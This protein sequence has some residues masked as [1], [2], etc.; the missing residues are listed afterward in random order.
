MAVSLDGVMVPMK[1]GGRAQKR[2]Q[3][4]AQDKHTFGPAGYQEVGCG[5]LSFYD[6]EGDRLST[7]HLGRMPEKHKATLKD[8]LSEELAAVLGPE[9]VNNFE[10]P[11][12]GGLV[13]NA[14]VP[15]VRAAW[16]LE[17]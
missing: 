14:A 4:K 10:T 2:E 6:A 11:V 5:T 8:A 12:A 17:G 16:V 15:R 13:S 3:A 1:D 9:C 7:V